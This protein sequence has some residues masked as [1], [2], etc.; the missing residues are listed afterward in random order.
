MILPIIV[1]IAF[2]IIVVGTY[3]W[4]NNKKK[5]NQQ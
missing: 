1:G 5:N 4:Y 3:S 2:V